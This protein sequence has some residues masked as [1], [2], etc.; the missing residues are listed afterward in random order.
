MVLSLKT[1]KSRSL[2][3][4]PR[5]FASPLYDCCCDGVSA[6]AGKRPP[7]MAA[8]LHRGPALFP[9]HSS[10]WSCPPQTLGRRGVAS[11]AAFL[12]APSIEIRAPPLPC[13]GVMRAERF[14]FRSARPLRKHHP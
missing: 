5:T 4:L 11:A 9:V 14:I 13:A 2:P 1:W 8:V 3:G 6:V 7:E 10:L 12:Y